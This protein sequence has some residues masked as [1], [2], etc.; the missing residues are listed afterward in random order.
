MGLFFFSF[1]DAVDLASFLR[2]LL[3][4]FFCVFLGFL[5]GFLFGFLFGFFL[6]PVFGFVV[7]AGVF[8]VVGCF[9]RVLSVFS[10]SV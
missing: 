1:L 8:A 4:V 9:F 5:C 7:F 6:F 10:L 2:F 3:F